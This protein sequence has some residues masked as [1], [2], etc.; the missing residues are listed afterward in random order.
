LFRS[1]LLL[2]VDVK[3]SEKMQEEIFSLRWKV[4]ITHLSSSL[5]DVFTENSFSDVTLVRDDLIQFQAHKC[6][7]SASSPVLKKLLLNNPHSH[8]LIYLRGIKHQE[9]ESILQF[10]YLGEARFYEGKKDRFME[11]VKDLEIKQ[12]TECFMTAG[13]PFV[14]IEEHTDDENMSSM[15]SDQDIS[16][17]IDNDNENKARSIS[18]T[19]NTGGESGRRLYKC[20]E[21]EAEFR[22][23]TGLG[24]HTRTKHEG[25]VYSC[26]QCEYKAT[27][28]GHL[29]T[30]KQSCHEGVKYSCHQCKYQATHQS[31]LKSHQQSK[32][33]GVK[34]SCHQCEYQA[35]T[36]SNLKTHQ[37]SKPE[38]I[39]YSCDQCEF[40][41]TRQSYLKIHQQSEHEGVKYFCTQC[42]YQAGTQS[43]LRRHQQSKH[44]RN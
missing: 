2:T 14:D 1:V 38:G 35:T 18:R 4:F 16:Q 33:E 17:I 6:V 13:N 22:S 21:C 43:N 26:N 42:D 15:T 40:Q 28:Q 7:L 23:K 37:Q 8:P 34:Y 31:H 41:A 5:S 29:K 30:H 3:S 12:L 32:H 9:L 27:K 25:I 24:H 11:A 39:K 19:Y 20:E 10:I 44:T 36:S